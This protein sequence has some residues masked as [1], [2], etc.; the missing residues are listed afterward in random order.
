MNNILNIK[1]RDPSLFVL[2]TEFPIMSLRKL[3]HA[4]YSQFFF[5]AV[6]IENIY[7]KVLIF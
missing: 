4:I 3:T 6:K 5:L 2:F 7:V 1:S